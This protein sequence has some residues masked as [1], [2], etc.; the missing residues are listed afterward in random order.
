MPNTFIPASITHAEYLEAIAPLLELLGVNANAIY[1]TLLIAGDEIHFNVVPGYDGTAAFP[2]GVSAGDTFP[3]NDA[4]CFAEF[5]VPVSVK[6][7]AHKDPA[8]ELGD[9]IGDGIAA[10]DRHA[11]LLAGLESR[12]SRL[13]RAVERGAR[14]GINDRGVQ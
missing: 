3:D 9:L 8:H 12:L 2:E 10:G 6:I 1:S 4:R 13:E 7:G 11:V 5:A 14:K